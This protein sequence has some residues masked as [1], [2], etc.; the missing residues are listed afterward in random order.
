MKATELAAGAGA[1]PEA[2][3]GSTPV[4]SSIWRRIRRDAF[5]LG[6]GNATLVLAQLGFRL[7]L[8]A[9][10]APASYGRLSLVLSI[11]NSAWIIGSSGL[12]NSVARYIA[13]NEP[14]NDSGVIRAAIR[15]GAL[16][17][18]VAASLVAVASAIVLQSPLAAPIGAL[19]FCG[20][21]YSLLT[22]GV[23]RGRGRVGYAASVMPIVGCFELALLLGLWR[24]GMG[25]APMSAFAIFAAGNVVGLAVAIYFAARTRVPRTA[26]PSRR[27]PSARELL[28]FSLWL[29]LAT[30]AVAILPLVVRTAASLDSFTVV[31][32]IDVALVLFSIPQRLGTVIVLATTPHAS[33][34]I[35][36][37]RLDVAISRREHIILIVPFVLG[38]AAV[39]FTP[40]V[41]WTFEAIGK[42][43]YGES[44]PYLALALLAGPPRIL[45]GL[46]EGML[47]AHGEGRFLAF[48]A[49]SLSLLASAAIFA[50]VSAGSAVTAFAVFVVAFWLIYLRGLRRVTRLGRT[51]A[52]PR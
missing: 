5:L 33:K 14:G 23:L 12:P 11:Y 10:L 42:P 4:G 31:A 18:G 19:G 2:P 34:Q 44:A 8:I 46:V 43:Q 6:A 25:V 37:G 49:V 20:L 47:I 28:S 36:E 52:T 32:I 45:Y 29:A 16:P 7:I 26:S 17:I 22:M 15:A 21:M 24:S 30:G 40:L 3:A 9:S 13:L 41:E 27:A 48:G 1:P 51:P 50:T 39:A 38:A 35:G